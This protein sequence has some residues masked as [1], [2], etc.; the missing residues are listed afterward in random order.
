MYKDFE[1]N[2]SPLDDLKAAAFQT[3]LLHPGTTERQD[4]ID[5]LVEE[6]GGEVMD[7]YGT[8]PAD[9]FP[10]LEDLWEDGYLDSATGIEKDFC[11]WA[12]AFASEEAVELYYA[13]VEEKEKNA[14]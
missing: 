7:A 8:D 11:E 10:S 13:L 14:R 3:L 4:W 2:Y 12:L 6:C 5:L 9:V 1:E